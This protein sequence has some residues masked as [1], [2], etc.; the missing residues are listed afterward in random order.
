MRQNTTEAQIKAMPE[1]IKVLDYLVRE[2]ARK[3]LQAALEVEI[4]EHLDRFEHLVD[5]Q[6]K[7]QVVRNGDGN[8]STQAHTKKAVDTGDRLLEAGQARIMN[9]TLFKD[10]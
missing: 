7:R 6:G 2:G 10:Q 1:T 9:M 5:T 3:M 4:Q 8:R